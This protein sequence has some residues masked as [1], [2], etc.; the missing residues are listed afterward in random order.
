M[1][2]LVTHQLPESQEQPLLL[3]SGQMHRKAQVLNQYMATVKKTKCGKLW[4]IIV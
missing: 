3:A 4:W 2:T 1:A